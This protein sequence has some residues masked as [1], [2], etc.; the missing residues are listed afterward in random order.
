MS[1]TKYVQQNSATNTPLTTLGSP[2]KK[3]PFKATEDLKLYQAKN[4]NLERVHDTM[5]NLTF[6]DAIIYLQ[7]EINKN[8]VMEH[9]QQ[10]QQLIADDTVQS[11]HSKGK[12][13]KPKK[14]E[15]DV[16]ILNRID[17]LQKENRFLREKTHLLKNEL[18]KKENLY[19]N[20]KLEKEHA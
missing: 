16:R 5:R 11:S 14:T 10:N 2:T 6:E 18:K 9:T 7:D 3:K 1:S 12:Q 4:D 13:K 15:V 17:V 19:M 20:E 8:A